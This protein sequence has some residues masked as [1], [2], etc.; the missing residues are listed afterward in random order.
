MSEA[1]TRSAGSITRFVWLALGLAAFVAMPFFI[2]GE[3]LE[4][5]FVNSGAVSFLERYGS[6]AWAI[7]IGLLV[8]D[9]AFP[10]PTSAVMAALGMIYGPFVGG[11]VAALGSIVSGLVGY[12]LC[13]HLG[14]PVALWLNG[15]QGMLKG[16]QIFSDIGGWLVAMSRWLPVVSEVVACMAGLSRMQFSIFLTA[17]I[18][19]SV[20]L[21]FTFSTIGYMGGDYPVLTLVL[22]AAL[23][24]ILWLLVRPF[25]RSL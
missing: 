4:Q 7:A 3:Q 16:E 8:A 2:F 19:G 13:R 24:F 11:V 14:R 12:L 23:P 21:G 1:K 9:L 10:I 22:S 18:C 25:L 20:P 17:L 5:V 15:E 6:F